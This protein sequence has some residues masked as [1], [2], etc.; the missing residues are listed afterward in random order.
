MQF[1]YYSLTALSLGY[2]TA[3]STTV[4]ELI[5]CS[6]EL[7]PECP[8]F[9]AVMES[10]NDSSPVMS[11][12]AGGLGD[13]LGQALQAAG[14]HNPGKTLNEDAEP[15][16]QGYSTS[17]SQDKVACGLAGSWHRSIRA[18]DKEG[19][20][21]R[22]AG[23]DIDMGGENILR[24]IGGKDADENAWPWQAWLSL[25][26][27]PYGSSLCGGTIISPRFI[28]TAA[29]CA[30]VSGIYGN[31]L[32]GTAERL[33]FEGEM[34]P[35]SRIIPHESYNKPQTFAYDFA[36][37]KLGLSDNPMLEA[38]RK[39]A[40]VYRPA[41]LP[42]E[43]ECLTAY[44]QEDNDCWVTGWGLQHEL[45]SSAADYMAE[46]DVQIMSRRDCNGNDNIP[47]GAGFYKT[48][49]IHSPS[50]FCAGW[51]DGGKDACSGDSGGP[52]VCRVPGK[53]NFQLYGVVSWGQGCGRSG[54]PGVY[55]KVTSIL[56][57]IKKNSGVNPPGAV[58]NEEKG[59][60]N[61]CIH[62]SGFSHFDGEG[63]IEEENEEENEESANA[64]FVA[65]NFPIPP[66]AVLRSKWFDEY[67]DGN[68]YVKYAMK[69][70]TYMYESDSNSN[71]GTFVSYSDA[72]FGKQHKKKYP[73]GVNAL[74]MFGHN[75]PHTRTAIENKYEP[76][77]QATFNKVQLATIK[78]A[79]CG[80]GDFMEV[81][82]GWGQ[83]LKR[84][85]INKK[86]VTIKG[87]CP[88][89]VN[90]VTNGDKKVGKPVSFNWKS[91]AMVK[92]DDNCGMEKEYLV[93]SNVW[94]INIGTKNYWKFDG[95]RPCTHKKCKKKI[96]NVPSETECGT[97]I[98]A[99]REHWIECDTHLA[100][101]GHGY[102]VPKSAKCDTSYIGFYDGMDGSD[103]V[104]K[105]V[106]CGKSTRQRTVFRSSGNS[107]SIKMVIGQL[108][109]AEKNKAV[110]GGFNLRC[111][112]VKWA[113]WFG[114]HQ[115][116]CEEGAAVCE[117]ERSVDQVH[118]S[119]MNDEEKK[120]FDCQEKFNN[121]EVTDDCL[122]Y[123]P[124]D[125]F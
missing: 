13:A 68:G 118:H 66:P 34:V 12:P 53:N 93:N 50:M 85:C 3:T 111:R 15:Y 105:S 17:D 91:Q 76:Q 48:S 41:C 113:T 74:W 20:R 99:N 124:D 40:G 106:I 9:S 43:G 100:Y 51:K 38:G 89:S 39:N 62:K 88:L 61:Y 63:E 79:K 58:V 94:T 115:Q 125:S 84:F 112:A 69:E 37:A 55:G 46:T 45:E 65:E 95:R 110:F 101:G 16:H 86:P 116:Q 117:T 44:E 14:G 25:Y 70:H 54:R 90:F 6:R 24:I 121:G 1:T 87:A 103:G 22:E 64:A 8:N 77:C 123:L 18:T 57:W 23:E 114:A 11:G 82:D 33:S 2:A 96:V 19:R 108:T 122:D 27:G 60:K 104:T 31:A 30:P 35:V 92:I 107:M 67:T 97:V 75:S 21:K 52:L 80:S 102:N 56:K 42:K 26:G 36:L 83:M 109:A 49:Y 71:G 10:Q 5:M 29:H 120:A 78:R 59:M 4:S 72:G 28:L 81:T 73:P 7:R 98:R 32:I 119:L 47:G